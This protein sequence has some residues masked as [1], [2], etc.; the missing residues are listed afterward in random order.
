VAR[1]IRADGRGI[2]KVLVRQCPSR[3][4]GGGLL[5]GRPQQCDELCAYAW[6]QDPLRDDVA[7]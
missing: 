2:V 4:R 7:G 3:R 6:L 5:A 1:S